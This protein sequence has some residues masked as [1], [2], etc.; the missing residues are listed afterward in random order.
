VTWPLALPPNL[1]SKVL[2][3]STHQAIWSDQR[4]EQWQSLK[5]RAV[6]VHH[7]I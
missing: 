6:H 5:V 2:Q 3:K 4:G 1:T 7:G